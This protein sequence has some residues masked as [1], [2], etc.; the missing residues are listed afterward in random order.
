MLGSNEEVWSERGD[1]FREVPNRSRSVLLEEKMSV[2]QEKVA[3]V[4][5]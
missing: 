1:H 2:E 3:A 5:K 4:F